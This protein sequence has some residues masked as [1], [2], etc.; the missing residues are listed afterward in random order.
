MTIFDVEKSDFEVNMMK[1]EQKGKE[2]DVG[3]RSFEAGFLGRKKKGGI[4]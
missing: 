2:N 3:E 1:N 4:P